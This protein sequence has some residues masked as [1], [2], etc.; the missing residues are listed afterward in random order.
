MLI[1]ILKKTVYTKFTWG[2]VCLCEL[3]RFEY[4]GHIL[5]AQLVQHLTRDSWGLG[6]NPVSYNTDSLIPSRGKSLG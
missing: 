3:H 2:I 1:K 5:V 6:S 4:Q